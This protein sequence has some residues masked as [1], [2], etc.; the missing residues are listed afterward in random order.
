MTAKDD[1]HKHLD[2]CQQ[3]RENPFKLCLTGA[4]LL[5]TAAMAALENLRRKGPV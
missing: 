3:C 4:R 5:E 2:E 1:F